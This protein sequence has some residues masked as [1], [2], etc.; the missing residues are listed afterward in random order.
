[1]LYLMAAEKNDVARN[2]Q[3]STAI[4]GLTLTSETVAENK[5]VFPAEMNSNSNLAGRQAVSI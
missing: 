5:A 4:C 3:N 1:M 2:V